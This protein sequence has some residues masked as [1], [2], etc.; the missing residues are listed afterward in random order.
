[1]D[2]VR[3]RLFS[4][5]LGSFSLSSSCLTATASINLSII[6]C[7]VLPLLRSGRRT[8]ETL[9][10]FWEIFSHIWL[11]R[12]AR[13]IGWRKETATGIYPKSW[14][15]EEMKWRSR[16]DI[17]NLFRLGIAVA[18]RDEYKAPLP[19]GISAWISQGLK[20]SRLILRI[21]NSITISLS[22]YPVT[23]SKGLK[24]RNPLIWAKGQR[25]HH[26]FY[27]AHWWRWMQ[28]R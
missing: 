15:A 24:H 14:V 19:T 9:G 11:P 12:T 28:Q 23:Q 4:A 21:L 16:Y 5:T 2:D 6:Y 8:S 1:M 22:W 18:G 10:I 20:A 13:S 25:R 7:G 27:Y 26:S 17:L 3:G